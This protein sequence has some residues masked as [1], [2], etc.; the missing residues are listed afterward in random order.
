MKNNTQLFKKNARSK[1]MLIEVERTRSGKY[2]ITGAEYLDI[3]NQY[4]SN[5]RRLDARKVF[6]ELRKAAIKRRRMTVN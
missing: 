6:G 1:L 2:H 5:W 3:T 4:K